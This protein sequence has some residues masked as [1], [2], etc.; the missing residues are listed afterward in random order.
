MLETW[1]DKLHFRSHDY[2]NIALSWL[3]VDIIGLGVW[4][5]IPV[6]FR[7][8]HSANNLVEL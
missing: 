7:L 4:D 3:V 6:F 2:I 5:K 8:P 1:L